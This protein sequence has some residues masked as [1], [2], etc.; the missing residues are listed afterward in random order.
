MVLFLL[1]VWLSFF[2]LTKN[3]SVNN[4]SSIFRSILHHYFLHLP[5]NSEILWC[6]TFMAITE[7]LLIQFPAQFGWAGRWVW[8]KIFLPP[9]SRDSRG[10]EPCFLLLR[11]CKT[12][13]HQIHQMQSS[14]LRERTIRPLQF[15]YPSSSQTLM[16]TDVLRLALRFSMHGWGCNALASLVYHLVAL[17]VWHGPPWMDTEN[18]FSSPSHLDDSCSCH[19]FRYQFFTMWFRAGLQNGAQQAAAFKAHQDRW[20]HQVWGA[21]ETQ[22]THSGWP[23]II[24][25]W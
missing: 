18:L 21:E 11:L 9:Q 17:Q 4:L 16:M 20:S 25:T 23:F 14:K 6:Q 1:H 8:N 2:N 13:S 7:H 12:L 19:T 15:R 24:K 5:K 3:F 22:D 10:Y